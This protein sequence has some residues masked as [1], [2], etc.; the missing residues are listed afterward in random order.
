VPLLV[1][2][3]RSADLRRLR[4]RDP[5]VITWGWTRVEVAGALERLSRD[6]KLSGP[7]RREA[8][9]RFAALAESW[10]EVVDLVA[11]RNRA[12]ALLGRHFLRA[13]D[14]AHL[15]AA[16]WVA[17]DDPSSLQFVCLD[18]RLADAAEREGLRPVT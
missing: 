14:A 9:D 12:I 3:P 1:E 2:E 18:R 10:H 11:V 16:L 17:G 13:A 4:A 6:G 15:G 7:R 8:H 5:A